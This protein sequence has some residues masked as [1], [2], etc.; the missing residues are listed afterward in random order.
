[1][2]GQNSAGS[3]YLVKKN[4]INL[5][6]SGE[7]QLYLL[8]YI[9][10]IAQLLKGN[11]AVLAKTIPKYVKRQCKMGSLHPGKWFIIKDAVQM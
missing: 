8:N 6:K 7:E 9:L 4:K 11:V 10:N 2:G 3:M 1:M 5:H